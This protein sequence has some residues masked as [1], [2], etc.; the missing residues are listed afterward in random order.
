MGMNLTFSEPTSGFYPWNTHVAGRQQSN[1][2]EAS[3]YAAPRYQNVYYPQYAT[4]GEP[5]P[6]PFDIIQSSMLAAHA[7]STADSTPTRN[8]Q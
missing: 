6:H 1:T 7:R 5:L 2:M 4:T 8:P 3:P